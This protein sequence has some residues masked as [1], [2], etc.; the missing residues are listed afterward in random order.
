[1]AEKLKKK[2]D[3]KLDP[4]PDLVIEVDITHDSLNKFPIYAQISIPEIWRHNGEKL[5]IH[6]LSGKDYLEVEKSF[7]FSLITAEVLTNF[8]Q[9]SQTMK[10]TALSKAFREWIKKQQRK[11]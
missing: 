1:M 9:K 6:R 7:A 10:S 2:I 5:S 3:L 11:K 8:L 4:P